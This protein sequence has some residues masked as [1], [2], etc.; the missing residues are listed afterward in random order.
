M[1][2]P[3]LIALVA[4]AFAVSLAA[5]V[6]VAAAPVTGASAVAP[7]H[8]HDGHILKELGLT[9][10]QMK[11][12]KAIRATAKAQVE[13]IKTDTTLSEADKK[14]KLK[15]LRKETRSQIE[16]ILTPDQIAKLKQLREARRDERKDKAAAA[17]E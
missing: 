5:N 14:S 4:S 2:K 11:S 15:A 8:K 6:S 10:D 3:T 9:K 12:I 16:A 1:N 7:A 17:A 13:S